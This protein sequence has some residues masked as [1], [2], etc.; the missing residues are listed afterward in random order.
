MDTS[1]VVKVGEILGGFSRVGVC[2]KLPENKELV[3]IGDASLSKGGFPFSRKCRAID[4]LRSL[5]F[6][7]Q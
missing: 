4:F 2:F 1:H 3:Y 5:S 6:V 7:L